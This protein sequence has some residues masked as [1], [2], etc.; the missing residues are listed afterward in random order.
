ERLLKAH[1]EL[2]E[3]GFLS[4]V[5]YVPMKNED[6]EQV[7]YTFGA[8]LKPKVKKLKSP[9]NSSTPTETGMTGSLALVC[10]AVFENLKDEDQERLRGEARQGV[11][12]FGWDRLENAES[13]LSWGLWEL[14]RR[15]F[16]EVVADA[17]VDAAAEAPN[18]SESDRHSGAE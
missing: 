2:E 1:T 17:V 6:G 7:I 11:P 10:K 18:G 16:A 9:G 8:G 12:D 15:D 3:R 4:A 14:V 5:A 13:P